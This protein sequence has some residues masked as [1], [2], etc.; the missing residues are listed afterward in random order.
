MLDRN[1]SLPPFDVHHEPDGTDDDRPQEDHFQDAE[2]IGSDQVDDIRETGGQT[3]D[4][5]RKNDE[6]DAVSD[7]ALGHLLAQP[8]DEGGTRCER[9]HRRQAK[10]PAWIQ[11][12]TGSEL[13]ALERDR[14]Q[15]TL[16][17]RESDGCIARPLRDALL[18]FAALLLESLQGRNHDRQ[19]LKDDRRTDV[20]HDAQRKNRERFHRTARKDV[21]KTEHRS[22]HI[23]EELTDDVA[24]DSRR[25]DD[26]AH[27]VDSEHG[28]RKE[29]PLPKFLDTRDVLERCDHLGGLHTSARRLDLRPGRPADL[30][31]SQLETLGRIAL[32][33]NL[34]GLA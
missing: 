14:H 22:R 13:T 20:G 5:A 12:R 10:C 32:G 8:H 7:A 4:D 31:H 9:D 34:Y 27:S 3:H 19:Q 28:S 25:H 26:T 23:A 17:E 18:S 6:R 33:K 1:P 2:L 16:E 29:D 11:D 21:Q 30:V 15:E 24:V